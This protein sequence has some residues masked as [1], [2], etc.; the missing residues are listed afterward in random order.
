MLD[1]EYEEFAEDVETLDLR[2]N[3]TE[4]VV[5]KSVGVEMP[6]DDITVN[7]AMV[8]KS[9]NRSTGQGWHDGERWVAIDGYP[10]SDEV[11]HWAEMLA[12]PFGDHESNPE[13]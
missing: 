6:D 2:H 11:T 12:G 4:V 5:W 9:G 7:L 10:L 13:E 1:G 3:T 8:D